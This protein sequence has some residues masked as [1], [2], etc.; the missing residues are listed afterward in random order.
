MKVK[1]GRSTINYDAKVCGF[2]CG[3]IPKSGC[4]WIVSCPDGKGGWSSVEGE[5]HTETPPP[6]PTVTVAGTLAG[7]AN[8]LSRLWKRP[9]EVPA[10]RGEEVLRQRT[11]GG[12]ADEIARRLGLNLN[13]SQAGGIRAAASAI[14]SKPERR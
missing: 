5:G 14:A 11:L 4:S 6:H 7:C 3:C 8:G 12:S 13:S 9:V 2:T 1:C 10:G